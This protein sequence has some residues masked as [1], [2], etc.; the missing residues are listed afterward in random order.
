MKELEIIDEVIPEVLGGAHRNVM[1]QAREIDRILAQSLEKLSSL[2]KD[3][4]LD[5]RYLKYRKIGKY[6]FLG[7]VFTYQ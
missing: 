5:M 7:S 3:E 2:D 1:D 6:N 4:L